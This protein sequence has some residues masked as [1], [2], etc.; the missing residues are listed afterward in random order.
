MK[1]IFLTLFI[2]VQLFSNEMRN[3]TKKD[4][5]GGVWIVSHSKIFDKTADRTRHSYLDFFLRPL[6]LLRYMQDGKLYSVYSEQ[7]PGKD[8]LES[9]LKA[10]DIFPPDIFSV[11]KNGII[12]VRR[13]NGDFAEQMYCKYYI[14]NSI[15]TNIPKGSIYLVRYNGSKPLV[16]NIYQRI[17]SNII[18]NIETSKSK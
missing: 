17:P 8:V 6:Q 5:E 18:K 4:L 10:F 1:L 9:S 11:D 13:Q 12:T 2:F 7:K 3:C 15:K 16:G 14:K